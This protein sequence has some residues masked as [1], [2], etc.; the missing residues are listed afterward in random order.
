MGT[1]RPC[2]SEGAARYVL[3]PLGREDRPTVVFSP[4][5][6]VAAV[7]QAS[8]YVASLTGV[9]DRGQIAR[10]L[11]TMRSNPLG[12]GVLELQIRRALDA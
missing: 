6:I 11:Q 2:C 12:R 3:M 5:R 1:R 4:V 8:A 7:K 10:K 9:S